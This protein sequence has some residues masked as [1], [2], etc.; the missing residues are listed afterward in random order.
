EKRV[1][2][3]LTYPKAAEHVWRIWWLYEELRKR[4]PDFQLKA[5]L[6]RGG[7]TGAQEVEQVILPN[8]SLIETLNQQ[9]Q[10]FQGSGYSG[11]TMEEF[12]LY[13]YCDYMYGQ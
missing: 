11:V 13:R 12:S 1:L 6:S 3:G 7:S 5:C 10:S 4:R 2:C 9:G 8:G